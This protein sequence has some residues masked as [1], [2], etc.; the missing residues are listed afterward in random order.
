LLC[1]FQFNWAMNAL[2]G[3]KVGVY[4]AKSDDPKD[5]DPNE[6]ICP[7]KASGECPH[8]FRVPGVYYFTSGII[9]D[10]FAFGGKVTVAESA[11]TVTTNIVVSINGNYKF[12]LLENIC[13]IRN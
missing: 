6:V 12:V 13:F 1:F 5:F 11:D 4:L 8:V 3:L 10:D 9:V 2:S 7:P